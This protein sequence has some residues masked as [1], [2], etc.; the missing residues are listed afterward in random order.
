MKRNKTALWYRVIPLTLQKWQKGVIKKIIIVTHIFFLSSVLSFFLFIL[1][2]FYIMYLDPIRFPVPLAYNLCPSPP[3][4]KEVLREKRKKLKK[5]LMWVVVWRNESHCINPFICICLLAS[6]HLQRV[7]GLVQ[8]LSFLFHLSSVVWWC[9][10]VRDAPLFLP[11]FH[12]GSL[13]ISFHFILGIRKMGGMYGI[14]INSLSLIISFHDIRFPAC[15][16]VYGVLCVEE[17]A[18]L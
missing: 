13:V 10:R 12:D 14:C 16:N 17:G 5:N 11:H 18:R 7:T 2:V 15:S 9:G 8:V 4:M 1:F 3:P 6:I